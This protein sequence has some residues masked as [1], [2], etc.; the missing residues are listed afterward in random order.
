MGLGLHA[1][2]HGKG[3][4]LH[5]AAVSGGVP[6]ACSPWLALGQ[7]PAMQPMGCLAPSHLQARQPWSN[8]KYLLGAAATQTLNKKDKQ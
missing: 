5:G 7:P 3:M 2:G 1:A 6:A 8:T 4:G